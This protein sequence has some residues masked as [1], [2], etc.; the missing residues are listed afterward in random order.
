MLWAWRHSRAE[1]RCECT[2]LRTVGAAL[3][4][5]DGI[6]RELK[7]L[8]VA[9]RHEG[10]EEVEEEDEEEREQPGWLPGESGKGSE[11]A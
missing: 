3:E 9:T 4:P 7:E 10:G 6:R 8:Q 1:S 5:S 11:R 2:V